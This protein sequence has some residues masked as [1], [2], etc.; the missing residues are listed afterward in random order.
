MISGWRNL[1]VA[2]LILAQAGCPSAPRGGT[3]P[4]ERAP[5]PSA[6]APA[7]APPAAVSPAEPTGDAAA[8]A[9]VLERIRQWDGQTEF[10]DQGRLI[11][12]DLLRASLSDAD[13]ELVAT[14][15]HLQR[16]QLKGALQVRPG[17][18]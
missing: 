18:E 15:P 12:V 3:E 5:G 7:A 4:S 16:L 8:F 1:C 14:L 11:A 10:D 2:S 6:A 9:P 13:V 17:F